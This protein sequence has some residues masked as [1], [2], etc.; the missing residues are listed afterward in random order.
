M[1]VVFH[2]FD[3]FEPLIL[4]FDTCLITDRLDFSAEFGIVVILLS[5]CMTT[6]NYLKMHLRIFMRILFIKSHNKRV[7]LLDQNQISNKFV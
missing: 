1:T 5:T 2:S 4:P 6:R 7:V 3:V